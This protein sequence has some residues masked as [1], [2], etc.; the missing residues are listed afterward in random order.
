MTR[1]PKEI[2]EHNEREA[3][4]EA[5]DPETRR[6]V[7]GGDILITEIGQNGRAVL[8]DATTRQFV[9]G[10]DRPQ[11]ANDIG[12][13]AKETAFKRTN[14]YREAWETMFQLGGPEGARSFSD[15]V[16]TLWWAA[17]GA[18]QL[19]DCHHAGCGKK[20]LAVLK[21]D[22]KVLM[23]MV[24]NL[25]GGKKQQIEEAGG[26]VELHKMLQDGGRSSEP[27]KIWTLDPRGDNSAD[28]RKQALLDDGT[29]DPTWFDDQ[30]LMD[31]P[32]RAVDGPDL[33]PGEV[34]GPELPP[35]PESP[36]AD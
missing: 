23:Q 32:E 36:V 1:S 33:P 19:A 29:I 15:L 7:E 26:I 27:T 12:Q 35:P 25:V 14:S 28:A 13:I 16:D 2:R 17:Q 5:M 8:V 34:I 18:P 9:T 6:L 21:P 31:Q 3:L 4:I 20:H 11:N 22:A 10:T 24:D 30:R